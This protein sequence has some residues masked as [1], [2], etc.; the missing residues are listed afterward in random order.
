MNWISTKRKKPEYGKRVLAIFDSYP[1]GH[2]LKIQ[3]ITWF[4]GDEN[5]FTYWMELPKE[6]E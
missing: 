6:P 4:D 5:D 1:K 2:D 3:I